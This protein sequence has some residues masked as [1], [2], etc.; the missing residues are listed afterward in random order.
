MHSFIFWT[1]VLIFYLPFFFILHCWQFALK[2]CIIQLS[3]FHL[4]GKLIVNTCS[5]SKRKYVLSWNWVQ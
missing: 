3:G 1:V 2:Y 4:D 5:A